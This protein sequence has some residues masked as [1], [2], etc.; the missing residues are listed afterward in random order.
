AYLVK[1]ARSSMLLDA[2][3]SCLQGRAADRAIKTLEMMSPAPET[4]LQSITQLSPIQVLVAE[5]NI[6]NQMVIKSMLEKIGCEA[7]IA[8]N[9]REAVDMYGAMKFD[10]VLMDIS[11]PE[12]DGVEATA[13][14]RKLQQISGSSTPIVGVTAHALAEDRQKC[15]DAGMDDYLPKPVKPD[16]LRRV[17]ERWS[18][19]DGALA[20]QTA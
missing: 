9:G 13:H 2:I 18:A 4:A 11:M 12:M 1:P 7:I 20:R 16:A 17:L 15:I 8:S 5:D 6:V 3:V 19:H 10:L 14:I